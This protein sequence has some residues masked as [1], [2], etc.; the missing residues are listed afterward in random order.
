MDGN[1]QAKT[2][3]GPVPEHSFL[4]AISKAIEDGAIRIDDCD[5]DCNDP[6]GVHSTCESHG[7][8]EAIEGHPDDVAKLVATPALHWLINEANFQGNIIASRFLRSIITAAAQTRVAQQ[9]LLTNQ[10][11]AAAN[12]ALET[13]GTLTETVVQQNCLAIV[14]LAI[15]ENYALD[16]GFG[17]LGNASPVTVK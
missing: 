14:K 17:C 15:Q 13:G 7:R 6:H 10:A 4:V 1:S 9:Q 2:P 5:D 12:K 3:A 11:I 8:V 16:P